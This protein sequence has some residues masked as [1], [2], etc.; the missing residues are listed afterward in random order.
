MDT[1]YKSRTQK[2]KEAQALQR[3]GE[4][5]VALPSG[6]LAAMELPDELLTAIKFARKIKSRGARRRQIQYIGVIMRNIDA[7]P[8]QTALERNP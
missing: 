3:L 7:Q 8:I 5:L 6:K 2:K 1:E 4:R